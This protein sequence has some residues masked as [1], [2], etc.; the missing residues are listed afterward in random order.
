[1]R[2]HF[3]L[4]FNLVSE[5]CHLAAETVSPSVDAKLDDIKQLLEAKAVKEY[6]F[7]GSK[8]GKSKAVMAALYQIHLMGD[9]PGKLPPSWPQGYEN[10]TFTPYQWPPNIDEQEESTNLQTHF[11]GELRKLK[12]PLG[13]GGFQ[14]QDVRG[15]HKLSF[16]CS[17]GPTAMSFSGGT[18]AVVTPFGSA[19]W[20]AQVCEVIDWKTPLSLKDLKDCSSVGDQMRLE[21]MGALYTSN[22]PIMA[23]CTDLNNFLIYVPIRKEIEYYHTFGGPEDAGHISTSNAMRLIAH[24]LSEVTSKESVCDYRDLTTAP[25]DSLLGQLSVPLLMAKEVAVAGGGLA[26]QP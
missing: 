23:I 6:S 12:V 15:Q 24:F 19:M 20:W 25:E 26:Q 13:Q 22:R 14:V 5:N 3:R 18:D 10:Y 16:Q 9:K 2:V 8:P 21:L 11:E 7:S 17:P 1:M 4:V